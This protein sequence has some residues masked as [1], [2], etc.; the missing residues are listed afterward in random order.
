MT[1]RNGYTDYTIAL[2]LLRDRARKF[3]KSNPTL[4]R[5]ILVKRGIIE[6]L[7]PLKKRFEN[8]FDSYIFSNALNMADGDERAEGRNPVTGAVVR[9]TV[10][11]EAA[12]KPA[13]DPAAIAARYARR[14][15][16]S[17]AS[18]KE[19]ER[20]VLLRMTVDCTYHDLWEIGNKL[21]KKGDKRRVA[22]NS[23][24]GQLAKYG[25]AIG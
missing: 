15:A 5:K 22:E 6:V 2:K 24:P 21:G 11:P 9:N 20:K 23:T 12:P 17:Q 14:L 10:E 4:S 1:R 16:N 25:V 19:V 18:E 13:P 7:R 8:E 3:A